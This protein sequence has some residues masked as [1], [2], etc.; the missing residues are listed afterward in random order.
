MPPPL[1]NT[2]PPTSAGTGKSVQNAPTR[3]TRKFRKRAISQQES[4]NPARKKNS[5]STFLNR[6]L[7]LLRSPVV[8]MPGLILVWCA[9]YYAFGGEVIAVQ[10]GY[11]WDGYIYGSFAWKFYR[12]LESPVL[13][14]YLA[15][16]VL[17]SAVLHYTMR[18]LQIPLEPSFILR[19]FIVLNVACMMLCAYLWARLGSL[20]ELRPAQHWLGYSGLFA[21]FALMKFSLYYPPLTDI[22]AFCLGVCSLYCY[23]TERT[24]LLCIVGGMSYFTF[25]TGFYITALLLAFPRSQMRE[26]FDNA[27]AS[28]SLSRTPQHR[29]I[30]I[31]STALVVTFCLV[32]IIY[33]ALV[34]EVRFDAAEP[35]FQPTLYLSIALTLLY[36]GAAA[37]IIGGFIP[38]KSLAVF[39]RHQFTVQSIQGKNWRNNLLVR[40][41]GVV[42]FMLC[43]MWARI[44]FLENPDPKI[45]QYTPMTLYRF[46][47]GSFSLAI[48][49]PLLTVVSNA[50]YFG[51]MVLA[52]LA[53]FR[54]ATQGALRLGGGFT[55][56]FAV[57][58]LMSSIMS[59]S[60][61]LI[62][63]YPF[64]LTALIVGINSFRLPGWMVIF[65]ATV[66]VASSKVWYTMNFPNMDKIAYNGLDTFPMQRYFMNH[67]PWMNMDM[68]VL[69]GSVV[70][71]VGIV[72]T[73]VFRLLSRRESA[74]NTPKSM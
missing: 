54:H 73:L 41:G 42:L 52:I 26:D 3:S 6:A 49:K 8:L 36:A 53:M 68:Y 45:E 19:G 25:P 47:G 28:T 66:G 56:V 40:A 50:V 1:K 23:L 22:P 57:C 2:T 74:E 14:P 11:G 35:I 38:W 43:L 15:Q 33:F 61:Q 48:A 7:A 5:D 46:F 17:P 24:L 58:A 63:L 71:G 64:V 69:Q 12:L 44:H 32:G 13:D 9:G 65:M 10:N 20:L 27:S 72:I 34:K 31:V 55:M 62:N 16:R 21:N 37:W 60:R 29:L 39:A 18:L 51:P 59:E 4:D 67:G 70:L 30:S